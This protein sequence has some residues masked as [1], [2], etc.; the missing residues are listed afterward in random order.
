M[1]R[2]PH[3]QKHCPPPLRLFFFSWAWSSVTRLG[4]LALESPRCACVFL[5]SSEI[6][7]VHH[8]PAYVHMCP[9]VWNPYPQAHEASTSLSELSPRILCFIS[10]ELLA[11]GR[12]GAHSLG[13]GA[14]SLGTGAQSAGGSPQPRHRSPEWGR[15]PFNPCYV[16]GRWLSLYPPS[17]LGR[18]G[19]RGG[20]AFQE[21]MA[22][23]L[24]PFLLG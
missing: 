14:H 20:K 17:G 19:R 9:G 22:T 10:V 5:S 15:V 21:R 8:A 7:G 16:L 23:G 1:W 12:P 6:T 13:T 4:L 3:P 2:H 24:G 18:N 11:P